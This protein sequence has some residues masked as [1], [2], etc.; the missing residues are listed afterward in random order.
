MDLHS[1]PLSLTHSRFFFCVRFILILKF[2]ADEKRR[3]K[4]ARKQKCTQNF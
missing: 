4:I 3:K 1:L 2:Y